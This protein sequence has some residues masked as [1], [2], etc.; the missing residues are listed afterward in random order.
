[1]CVMTLKNAIIHVNKKQDSLG[2]I[3]FFTQK[4]RFSKFLSFWS[5]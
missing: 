5:I 3:A 2:I 1:M 4:R